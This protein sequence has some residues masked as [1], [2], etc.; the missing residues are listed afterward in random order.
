MG[1]PT[2]VLAVPELA[3]CCKSKTVLSDQLP[4]GGPLRLLEEGDS[5]IQILWNIEAPGPAHD[6]LAGPD[7]TSA[8]VAG[9]GRVAW[10]LQSL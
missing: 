6:V 10:F 3:S 1:V 4:S 5:P 7:A 9:H 8:M 2:L